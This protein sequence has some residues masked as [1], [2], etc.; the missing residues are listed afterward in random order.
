M[1]KAKKTKKSKQQKPK[2]P[3]KRTSKVTKSK[4]EETMDRKAL[5]TIVSQLKE[6]GSDVKVFKSDTDEALQK[7]VNEALQK[8]PPPDVMK[9]LET[10]VPEK[11]VTVL[12]RDCIGL[13]IDLSDV[14]CVRCK[15]S[16]VCASTFLKN[17]KGGMDDVGKAMPDAEVEKV[18]EKVK[19]TPVTR[20]ESKRLVF[21]RDI[22]NPNPVGDDYH[23]AF[24]R[25]LDQQPDNLKE[26]RAIIEEDFDIDSD[27]DFMKFV[28]AMRDPAEGIIK[29]DVDLSD[30]NKA[31]LRK[32]GYDV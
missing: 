17:V 9:K 19:L 13:F 7:K 15:D 26:L 24:Q 11:L 14:S 27:G 2:A 21:V 32:A 10:I 3:V 23:D 6:M 18:A 28:T 4:P 5:K 29:L 20:Y 25:V 22:K 30:K 1:K 16:A 12:K 8:L 31:E